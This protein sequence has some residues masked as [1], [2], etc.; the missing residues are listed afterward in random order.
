MLLQ[1]QPYGEDHVVE[2]MD[3][4]G[5]IQKRMGT[6][7]RN[8][9][10]QYRGQKLA[11]GKTIGGTGRLTDKVINLWRCAASMTDRVPLLPSVTGYSC[12]HHLFQSPF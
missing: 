10:S 6:A 7:L 1:I 8:L 4:V 12:H 11:D 3:R 5:H 2:K 9:K